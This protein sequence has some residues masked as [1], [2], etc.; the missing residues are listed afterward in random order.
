MSFAYWLLCGAF[1][2]AVAQPTR[3][4]WLI[5]FAAAVVAGLVQG[6]LLPV[7]V[8]GLL[9]IALSSWG[10]SP[11]RGG[12]G[13]LLLRLFS[14]AVAF[15]LALHLLPGFKNE[16][17]ALGVNAQGEPVLKYLNFDKGAAGLVLFAFLCSRFRALAEVTTALRV[18][19]PFMV[20]TV[21]LT[22][23]A[24]LLAGAV[25]APHALPS[26]AGLFLISNLLFTCV[27]EEAA[28]R[29]VV[30]QML[31]ER[32]GWNLRTVRGWLPVVISSILFALVHA[33]AGPVMVGLALVAGIGYSL[34]FA[35]TRRVELSIVT[36]FAVNVLVFLSLSKGL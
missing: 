17:Y 2:A 4:L 3:Q 20:G 35:I 8:V 34:V 18:G 27:A 9:L 6:I 31:A 5:P 28:F 21:A 36:H 23:I 29:G 10:A 14:L 30:Q 13:D 19:W 24:A 12:A 32:L 7:A 22:V 26:G 15:A 1:V 25:A 16:T 33:P 11:H